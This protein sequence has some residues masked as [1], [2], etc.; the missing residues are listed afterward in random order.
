[1]KLVFTFFLVKMLLF[2]FS[3]IVKIKRA[4]GIFTFMNNKVFAI[5]YRFKYAGTM[6]TA[7]LMCFGEAVIIRQRVSVETDFTSNLGLLFTIIPGKKRLWSIADRTGA[8]I[9]NVAFNPAESRLDGFAIAL[10][11]IR[12]KVIPFPVLF[13]GDDTGKFINSEFLVCR[14]F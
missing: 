7:E 8:V 10:F 13:I 3:E 2:Y 11:I 6:R 14:R 5:L 9:R 1:M 12:N 4:L